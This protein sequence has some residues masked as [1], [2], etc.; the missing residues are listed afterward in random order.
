[1]N[2]LHW[3]PI[4]LIEFLN[5]KACKIK[6]SRN[7]SKL[8]IVTFQLYFSSFLVK[9]R[10]LRRYGSIVISPIK[11]RTTRYPCILTEFYLERYLRIPESHFWIIMF[12]IVFIF[13][14]TWIGN[15]KTNL[16]ITFDLSITSAGMNASEINRH[17]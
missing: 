2:F 11:T 12:A 17:F 6:C 3:K 16:K 4:Y 1:M 13:R 5:Y 8:I 9:S 14:S 7:Q 10:I 15:C